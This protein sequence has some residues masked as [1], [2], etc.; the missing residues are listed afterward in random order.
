[1]VCGNFSQCENYVGG[2]SCQCYDGYEGVNGTNCKGTK[3][4]QTIVMGL[5]VATVTKNVFWHKLEVAIN[6]S[7]TVN[8]SVT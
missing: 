5:V 3:Y 8:A 2:Y 4:F 7:N 6:W 1:M